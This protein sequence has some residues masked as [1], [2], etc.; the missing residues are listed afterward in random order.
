MDVLYKIVGVKA[1]A[2]RILLTIQP[3]DKNKD[4]NTTKILGNLGGFMENM[5]ADATL[6][7]NPDQVSIT[8]EEFKKGFYGLGDMI[9]VSINGGS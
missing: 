8:V 9:S 3:V 5:K 1:V 2:D 4:F 6:S 7:R